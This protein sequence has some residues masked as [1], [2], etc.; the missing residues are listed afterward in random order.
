M[1]ICWEEKPRKSSDATDKQKA[2][3]PCKAGRLEAGGEEN[4][5]GVWKDGAASDQESS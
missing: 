3:Q 5:E 4:D 1:E 2:N